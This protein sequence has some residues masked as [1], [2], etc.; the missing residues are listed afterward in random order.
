MP[1]TQYTGEMRMWLAFSFFL[2][3][4]ALVSLMFFL[5]RRAHRNSVP[6]QNRQHRI[7]EL[8]KEQNAVIDWVIQSGAQQLV[9]EPELQTE[10]LRLHAEYTAE[11]NRR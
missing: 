2:I 5:M 1:V 4:F 9:L 3:I 10:L 6:E 8:A 11:T 7:A